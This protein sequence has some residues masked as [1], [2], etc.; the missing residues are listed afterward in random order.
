MDSARGNFFLGRYA[1]APNASLS[2]P[3]YSIDGAWVSSRFP[4]PKHSGRLHIESSSIRKGR[5]LCG[6]CAVTCRRLARVIERAGVA[7]YRRELETTAEPYARDAGWYCPNGS[8]PY[9][10]SA[11]ARGTRLATR[12]PQRTGAA[13]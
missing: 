7:R 5:S 6:G 9:S 10:V 1:C 4:G 8:R 2:A 3:G 12:S 13:A 11:L